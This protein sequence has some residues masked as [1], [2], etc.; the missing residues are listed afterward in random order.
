MNAFMKIA[1]SVVAGLMIQSSAFA[2]GGAV[3]LEEAV[4]SKVMKNSA[5][6]TLLAKRIGFTGRSA[7]ELN[8]ALASFPNQ[9]LAASLVASLIEFDKNAGTLPGAEQ[10]GIADVAFLQANGT[11]KELKDVTVTAVRNSFT[12]KASCDRELTIK[13]YAG[14]ELNVGDV[15]AGYTKSANGVYMTDTECAGADQTGELKSTKK[16]PA[17]AKAVLLSAI[18]KVQTMGMTFAQ[19]LPVAQKENGAKVCTATECVEAT[20]SLVDKCK[21]AVMPTALKGI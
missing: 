3:V 20:K 11:A 8:K 14:S 16:Y 13:E 9:Q 19:A 4:F 17:K 5:V 15:E 10:K 6:Q 21:V 12:Q 1:A 18:R 7:S 2:A